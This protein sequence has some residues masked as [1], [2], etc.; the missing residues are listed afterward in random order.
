MAW[1][2]SFVLVLL[3]VLS[4]VYLQSVEDSTEETRDIVE[5]KP[6]YFIENMRRISRTESGEIKNIVLSDLVVHYPDD[7]STELTKPY[8]EIYS[9]SKEPWKVRSI[10][11]WIA[12]ENQEILLEGDVNLWRKDKKG[13]VIY[14]LNTEKLKIKPEEKYAETSSPATITTPESVTNTVGFKF[15]F[16]NGRIEL[17][18][19]VRTRYEKK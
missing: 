7:D 11:A 1:V 5:R 2:S 15:F 9:E 3:S 13:D 14:T 6:D 18:N 17:S 10:S 12:K 16:E 19:R 4:F 8:M